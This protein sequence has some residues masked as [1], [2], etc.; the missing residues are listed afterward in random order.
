MNWYKAGTMKP[1]EGGYRCG[2]GPDQENGNGV[3]WKGII[4]RAIK[5]IK[6]KT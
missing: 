1:I 3:G 4:S 5:D 6:G 2:V